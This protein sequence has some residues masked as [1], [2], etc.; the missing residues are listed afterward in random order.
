MINLNIGGCLLALAL[1][2]GCDYKIAAEVPPATIAPK[3]EFVE[4]TV[5]G[6]E[7]TQKHKFF[8][9]YQVY[10]EGWDTLAQAR[11][12]QDVIALSHDSMIL[13]VASIRMQLYKVPTN[14]WHCQSEVEKDLY[15]KNLVT[16]NNLDETTSIYVTSGKKFFF[17][18]RK[19]LPM[20]STALPVFEKNNTDPWYAQTI[21]LIESPGKTEARSYVG[22]RGPFQLMPYVARKYG[23]VVSKYRDDRTNLEKSAAAAAKLISNVCI[24]YARKIL[25]GKSISYNEKDLW[26]R[27]F[28]MHIYHA[29]A[30]NV[31][32]VIN[33]INPSEGGMPLIRQMWL[34]EAAGFKNE[35]QNYS[36]IALASIINFDRLISQ[37]KD[38]VYL[39]EGDK[40]MKFFKEK[41]RF[42]SIGSRF[43]MN[44]WQPMN[45]IWL[46]AQ[47]RLIILLLK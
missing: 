45:Q 2:G 29:G 19:V 16:S 22:A 32:A 37:D 6:F 7:A 8:N 41:P 43:L 9:N 35:S 18:Y 10:T 40:N 4:K 26:F 34:T 25:D 11:F 12:W 36:Q 13:N 39:I 33:K 24:P 14:Q 5:I 42:V 21:L 3:P 30:G 1:L 31:T 17:E 38:T 46:K 47:F 15:K 28:V 27:L 20:I 44:V 23:L